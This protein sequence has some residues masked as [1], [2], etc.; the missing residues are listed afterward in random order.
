MKSIRNRISFQLIIALLFITASAHAGEIVS[1]PVADVR[2][3]LAA[4]LTDKGWDIVDPH[5]TY[6]VFAR[7]VFVQDSNPPPGR[8]FV[9]VYY[10]VESLGENMVEI[11]AVVEIWRVDS[12]GTWRFCRQPEE[13]EDAQTQAALDMAKHAMEGKRPPP[14]PQ[15]GDQLA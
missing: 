10:A 3:K 2:F 14:G 11:S 1:A 6:P 7:D 12:K 13:I 9:F 4:G 5:E 8:L 15:P